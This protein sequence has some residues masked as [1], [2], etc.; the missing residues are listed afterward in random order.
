VREKAAEAEWEKGE[1]LREVLEAVLGA[2]SAAGWTAYSDHIDQKTWKYATVSATRHVRRGIGTDTVTAAIEMALEKERVHYSVQGTSFSSHGL[3]MLKSAVSAA[4]EEIG[5]TGAQEVPKKKT[6]D[7]PEGNVTA[8][9]RVRHILDRFH[10][11]TCELR[12]RHED[13]DTILIAD[14]YDVQDVLRVLLRSQFDDVRPEEPTPSKAGGSARMDFMLKNECIVVECK[15][16]SPK[17][18]D[19][20]IGEELA[21]DIIRYQAHPGCKELFCLV[22]DPASDVRNP[23]GLEG[24]MS[25]TYDGLRVWLVVVPK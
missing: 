25:R 9:Q 6:P 24:D 11:I 10:A 17:L 12:R 15:L 20:K 16:A 19:K 4:L 18:R 22:Y 7:K 1:S 5:W 13:R 3:D 14:E 21:A 23:A 2:C 8:S